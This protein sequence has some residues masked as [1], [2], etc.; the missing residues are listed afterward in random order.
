M[1][2]LSKEHLKQYKLALTLLLLIGS[3]F[4]LIWTAQYIGY[5]VLEGTAGT[6]TEVI[7][8][9]RTCTNAWGSYYGMAVMVFNYSGALFAD[10][11]GCEAIQK[12]LLFPC[13]NREDDNEVYV[14]IKESIDINWD[15]VTGATIQDINDY[16][17]YSG[18]E[19]DS[20][21]YTF[22]FNLS[23]KLGTRTVYGPAMY[24]HQLGSTGNTTDFPLVVLKEPA[25]N[26]LI[27]VNTIAIVGTKGFNGEDI[28][29][30]VMM[31]IL[32]HNDNQTETY[33]FTADPYEECP[34]GYGYGALGEGRVIGYVTDNITGA[35]LED[36]AI[37][38]STIKNYSNA[39]GFF[40]FS[41]PYGAQYILGV[42]DGY[43]V[44]IGLI[45][46]SI[47]ERVHYN[48]TMI[49]R[50]PYLENGTLHGYVF[51]NS[52]NLLL[53]NV[54]ITFEGN[55]VTTN[56][57]GEYWFNVLE[58]THNLVGDKQGYDKYAAYISILPNITRQHN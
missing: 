22:E 4:G 29:Y 32:N 5:A 25:T 46:V 49:P 50:R 55:T 58:G 42:K 43:D 28:N 6:I 14:S 51:D 53:S 57:S 52:T 41:V 39:S 47:G 40:N 19:R 23:V 45:N 54:T 56:S 3:I 31:P 17:N 11:Y 10:A 48:F 38:V 26:T 21:N 1:K 33:Y 24:T 2:E 16:L 12:H 15:S 30:Q 20:A 36:V 18:T 35:P 44:H 7:I 8:D 9:D 37:Y 27:F 34:A 13:L